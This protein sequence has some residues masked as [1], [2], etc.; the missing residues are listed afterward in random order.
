[1]SS[2]RVLETVTFAVRAKLVPAPASHFGGT[3]L[4][5]YALDVFVEVMSAIKDW[6]IVDPKTTMGSPAYKAFIEEYKEKSGTKV[7]IKHLIFWVKTV[8]LKHSNMGVKK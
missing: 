7:V 2:S 8:K 3:T 4:A 1:M 6:T 5:E